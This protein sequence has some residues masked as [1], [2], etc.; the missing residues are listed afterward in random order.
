[1]ENK[2]AEKFYVDGIGPMTEEQIRFLKTGP[3]TLKALKHLRSLVEMGT[4]A[5]HAAR[6]QLGI[7]EKKL[8]DTITQA[9]AKAEGK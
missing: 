6:P 8:W 3:E 5:E 1:M 2:Q 4:D 7:W 9:I